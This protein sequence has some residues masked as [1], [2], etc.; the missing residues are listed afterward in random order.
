M[1]GVFMT[2]ARAAISKLAGTKSARKGL[3]IL[4]SFLVS[5]EALFVSKFL[6]AL[7]TGKGLF[8]SMYNFVSFE[9]VASR[10]TLP[11]NNLNI[12]PAKKDEHAEGMRPTRTVHIETVASRA[13]LAKTID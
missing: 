7:G 1:H 9:S 3:G 10:K 6:V 12:E 8:R 4:M 2:T 13:W 11:T 5:N